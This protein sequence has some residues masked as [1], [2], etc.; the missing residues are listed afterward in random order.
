MSKFKNKGVKATD[1]TTYAQDVWATKGLENKRA[2]AVLVAEH[3]TAGKRDEYRNAVAAA[4]TEAK[5][6]QLVTNT[7]LSGEGNRVVK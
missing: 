3:M 2:K 4:K 1:L 7:M 5:L 6:D